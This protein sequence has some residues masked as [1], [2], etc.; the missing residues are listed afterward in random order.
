MKI[1]QLPVV[2]L[3]LGSWSCGDPPESSGKGKEHPTPELS[4]TLSLPPFR[5]SRSRDSL[6]A[7]AYWYIYRFNALSSSAKE[8]FL[9]NQNG[10][11]LRKAPFLTVSIPL[12]STTHKGDTATYTFNLRDQM[13]PAGRYNALF[14]QITFV[15]GQLH[16]GMSDDNFIMDL[17]D[18]PDQVDT[19]FVQELHRYRG[20]LPDILR[21]E[22]IRRAV[23]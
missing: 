11:T 15:K 19:L 9:V 3:I 23:Y 8:V 4:D 12:M 7:R 13:V 6:Y 18:Y 22:A 1:S 10:D 21:K 17:R 20:E 2:L 16:S 5:V 14:Y